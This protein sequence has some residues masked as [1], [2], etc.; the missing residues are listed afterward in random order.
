MVNAVRFARDGKKC[1]GWGKCK[2]HTTVLLNVLCTSLLSFCH[3]RSILPF[4]CFGVFFFLVVTMILLIPLSKDPGVC[5]RGQQKPV[6]VV[7]RPWADTAAWQDM[8]LL[9]ALAS[10]ILLRW[11]AEWKQL[12]TVT[13]IYKSK[14][15]LS[16]RVP[17]KL[18]C[19]ANS[20]P[21][22]KGMVIAIW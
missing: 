11:D 22:E 4:P 7:V 5:S 19:W 13:L 9:W 16:S 21:G 8:H 17:A 2:E 10:R 3:I 15:S 1:L 12:C 18:H 6:V 14:D 20:S